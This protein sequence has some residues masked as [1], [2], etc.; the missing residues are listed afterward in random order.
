MPST[1][2]PALSVAAS[3]VEESREVVKVAVRTAKVVVAGWEMVAALA[4]ALEQ[5]CMAA[6]A[7][8]AGQAAMVAREE[9]RACPFELASSNT[10]HQA[11]WIFAN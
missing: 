11:H 6:L 2:A 4:G 7:A 1:T 3:E 5:E 8:M 9:G 10:G